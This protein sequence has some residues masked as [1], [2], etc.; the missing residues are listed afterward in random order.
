MKKEILT[1][2]SNRP[3]DALSK[4][5][6]MEL[7]GCSEEQRPGQF[8]NIE[9]DGLFLRRPI[10]VCDW[11]DGVLTL[12]YKLVGKGTALMA[13]LQPG[14]RLDVLCSLGNGFD[15]DIPALTRPDVPAL[16]RPLLVGGGI[17]T[18][19]L[20]LLARRLKERGVSPTVIL[21]FNTASEIIYEKEFK[22][23]GLRTLVTT[24][25]GSYGTP[26]FVTDALPL[27]ASAS[28]PSTVGA[29]VS[30]PSTV[31]DS[32]SDPST[33]GDSGYD[34]CYACGPMPMLRALAPKLASPAQFSL[35]ERMGCGTG[36]C[37]GCTCPQLTGTKRICKDGPVFRLDEISF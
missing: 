23:L 19:P 33:V 32:V 36:I 4:V 14:A 24:V 31:G 22:A 37:M 17:G 30:N 12:L 27:L 2:I 10:S 7:S 21:G 35:E 16:T 8:V 11:K 26:G 5:Y 6:Q 20:Y 29:S 15:I 34:Y 9:L 18:A 13:T 3:V 25:D 28:A 1:V